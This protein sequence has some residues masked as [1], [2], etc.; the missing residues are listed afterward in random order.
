[1][2]AIIM[3][4]A[5]ATSAQAQHKIVQRFPDSRVQFWLTPGG[6]RPPRIQV[7][8]YYPTGTVTRTLSTMANE[9]HLTISHVTDYRPMRKAQTALPKTVF[10]QLPSTVYGTS[11]SLPDTPAIVNYPAL[12]QNFDPR[13]PLT[14]ALSYSQPYNTWRR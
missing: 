5:V 2:A 3:A 11:T 9:Q 4:L 1:M 12:R 8:T 14:Q 7:T 10:K 6:T 13:P